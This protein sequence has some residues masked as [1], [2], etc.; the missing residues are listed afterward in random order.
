M[1]DLDKISM[2]S[3]PGIGEYSIPEIYPCMSLPNGSFIPANYAKTEQHPEN[4]IVHFFVH[5]YQFDRFWNDPGRYEKMLSRF[6][7]VLSPDFSVYTDMPKA[8]QIYNHYKKHWLGAYWDSVGITV[9]PTISWGDKSSF[10]WCFD[11]EPVHSIVAVSSIGTQNSEKSKAL[12]L[13][14]YEEMMARLQPIQVL[15]YGKVPD[16]CKGNILKIESFCE[17]LKGRV[18]NGR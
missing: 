3:F 15:F 16:E 14:G 4:K 10:A 18:N 1:S 6:S 5:D 17:K 12:F 9:I 2:I 7:A 13:R 11:G 8:M